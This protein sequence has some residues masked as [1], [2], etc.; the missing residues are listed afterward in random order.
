MKLAIVGIRGLPNNYGGFETLAEYLVEYLSKD[1]EITVYCSS[2]DLPYKM[3]EFNGSRLKYIP[4]S[5]HGAMG[6]LYDSISLLDAIFRHDKVLFLGFGGG[7]II[8]LLKKYKSKIILNV[9]GMDWKRS[10]WGSFAKKVIKK[11]E[12]LLMKNSGK[13]ISDNIAVQNYILS[14]YGKESTLIGYGGDQA[15][16]L[17]ASEDLSVVYPFLKKEYAFIVTRIQPDN[18][19]DMILNAF[20]AAN[21]LPLVMVGNWDNSKYGKETKAKFQNKENLILLDAIY[22]RKKLDVLRSNC[23]LYIHGHSA[24]G[25]NPS[26]VEAMFLGL[27]VYAFASG[28]NEYTTENEAIYFKNAS[29]LTF[30][31]QNLNYSSISLIG[32]NLKIIAEKS[33]RW[34]II[35]DKYKRL[36]LSTVQEN[37]AINV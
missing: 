9:G 2:K 10:K 18:N 22:E 31:I 27:P 34:S 30:L 16:K 25:T 4:I 32:V 29:D 7:F 17:A 12:A 5:S 21:R 33:Y 20:M 26:L 19:I 24:G 11:S 15:Q 36:I 23:S 14:E 35:A 28:F 6:I 37:I 13:I 8:P 3:K 1:F